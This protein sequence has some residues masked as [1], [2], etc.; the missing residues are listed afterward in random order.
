M[1]TVLQ[2]FPWFK[3]IQTI[4]SKDYTLEFACAE[5]K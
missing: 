1:E 2:M 3:N 4:L 5:V